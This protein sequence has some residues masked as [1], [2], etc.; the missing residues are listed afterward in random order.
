MSQESPIVQE[1]RERRRR[2]SDAL[3][4]DPKKYFEFLRH[5]QQQ[6]RHRLVNQITVAVSGVKGNGIAKEA[7]DQATT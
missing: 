2:I 3:G 1:V 7:E 4:N 5:S 6:Y